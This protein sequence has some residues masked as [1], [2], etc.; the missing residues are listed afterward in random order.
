M[1]MTERNYA[2]P[3]NE[4]YLKIKMTP[5]MK[6]NPKMKTT[7]KIKTTSKMKTNPKIKRTKRTNIIEYRNFAFHRIKISIETHEN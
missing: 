6:R 4:D 5:K 1:Q 7:P 2:N 3:K